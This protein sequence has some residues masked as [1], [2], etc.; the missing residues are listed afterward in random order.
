MNGCESVDDVGVY[1][2]MG[3][4]GRGRTIKA[5]ATRELNGEKRIACSVRLSVS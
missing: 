3:H 5:P 2:D 1:P 4:G